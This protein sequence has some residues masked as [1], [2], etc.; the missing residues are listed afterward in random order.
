VW[1]HVEKQLSDLTLFC[2]RWKPAALGSSHYNCRLRGAAD[3]L[4]ALRRRE[5]LPEQFVYGGP[6]E[7]G[8]GG[9]S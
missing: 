5:R 6:G 7:I 1:Y 3:T 4:Y 8:E 9:N 2:V